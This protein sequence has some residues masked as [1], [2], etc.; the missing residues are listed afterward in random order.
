MLKSDKLYSI[1]S[2]ISLT[3]LKQSKMKVAKMLATQMLLIRPCM[4]LN[5]SVYLC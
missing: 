1:I 5:I 4:S 3:L 2:I